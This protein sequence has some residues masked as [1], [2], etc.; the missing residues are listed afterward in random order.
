MELRTLGVDALTDALPGSELAAFARK[1]E[2]LGYGAF[3][4][5]EAFGRDPF[6][7]AALLL[8]ATDK[9]IVGTA[10]ANVWKRDPMAM[11][12]GARTLAEIYPDRFVL[13]IGISHGPMM[14]RVGIN[15]SRPLS[16][17]R[18]YLARLKSAPYGAPAPATEPPILVAALLPKMLALAA[19][20]T[21]GTLPTYITP[22]RT[23]QIR[24]QLGP[25]KLLCVQQVAML[26]TDASKARAAIRGVIAF[27]LG[28]PNYLRSLKLMGF[29][30]DDFANGG[31]DRLVDAMVAWGGE[32]KIRERIAAHYDAGATHVCITPVR[33]DGSPRQRATPD[34][35]A[36]E[37]LAPH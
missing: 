2:K 1:I 20:E 26:E 8:G 14:S 4:F 36:L 25:R 22:A 10:I 18:D 23:A 5:P 27:Y 24:T 3:W 21:D 17:M 16:Y 13:G 6:A 19:A 31:S 37:A 29:G 33:S 11:I 35:R 28:L 32:K 12:A 7:Q 30:D 9:L 15:Y 34:D